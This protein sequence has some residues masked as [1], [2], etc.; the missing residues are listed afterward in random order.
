VP[1][2][3]RLCADS[4]PGRSLE[5]D[6]CWASQRSVQWSLVCQC[7]QSL[8]RS[9][10]TL[11]ARFVAAWA[12][13]PGRCPGASCTCGDAGVNGGK[14]LIRASRP[15]RMDHSP[16]LTVLLASPTIVVEPACCSELTELKVK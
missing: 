8:P 16:Q 4:T 9:Y 14:S 15:A 3:Q 10:T 12:G 7:G 1:P 2:L 13:Q 6:S 11:R 5:H